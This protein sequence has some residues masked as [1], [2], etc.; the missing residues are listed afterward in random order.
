MTAAV[1]EMMDTTYLFPKSLNWS[2]SPSLSTSNT[3]HTSVRY[4][5]CV[6]AC[7][8]RTYFS[9]IL[10]QKW[11]FRS[12]WPWKTV[13]RFS[14]WRYHP[15]SPVG[16]AGI[17]VH[18]NGGRWGA[19]VPPLFLHSAPSWQSECHP[20]PVVRDKRGHGGEAAGWVVRG[21][22]GRCVCWEG[23]VYEVSPEATH[24]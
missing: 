3:S 15:R 20:V 4:M 7:V 24:I 1:K 13:V 9:I 23:V 8:W 14:T 10:N 17:S 19:L 22:K 6:G 16:T 12:D 18:G 11:K 5:L 2:S 21:E